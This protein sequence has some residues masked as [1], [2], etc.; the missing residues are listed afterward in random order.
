MD[1]C[2]FSNQPCPYQKTTHITELKDGQVTELHLCQKCA[3]EYLREDETVEI[4]ALPEPEAPT[5]IVPAAAI[6][7]DASKLLTLL[8][9]LLGGPMAPKYNSKI[10]SVPPCPNCGMTSA[11]IVKTGRFGCPTCYTH[12]QT[13]VHNVVLRCQ[14]DVKHVGKVPKR[15]AAEREQRRLEEE[16][17]LDVAE[18]IRNL[19]GKMAK[20]VEVENYEVAAILKK[21]IEELQQ[22]KPPTPPASEG[23]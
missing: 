23:Q 18:K 22:S 20:A 8:Q 15:W 11:E 6:P 9:M 3:A 2:P 14:A 10:R 17:A 4:E 16:A 19:K 7:P 1:L 5:P 21:K 13:A 12:Y